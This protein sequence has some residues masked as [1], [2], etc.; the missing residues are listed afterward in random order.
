MTEQEKAI[1]LH[2]AK[3]FFRTRIVT[4]HIKNTIKCGNLAEFNVN[5]FLLKYLAYYFTGNN[6]AES[7]A[8]C[9]IYPRVLGTSITTS[10]GSQLQFFCS[11]V[12]QGYASVIPG[13]DL[14]FIDQ[15]DGRR[16]YCQVKAGPNTINAS[17]VETVKNHFTGIRNL[18]RV[19]RLSLDLSDLIVGVFYGEE[20]ELSTNYIAINESFPVYIGQEFWERLTGE[21]S[22][23][24]ELIDAFGEV[25]I[26]VDGVHMLEQTVSRLASQI[27]QMNF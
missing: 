9:L 23:Y 16:K 13:L 25:A 22:F 19:N 14:E 8:K 10:F 12:L 15:I 5:P 26:E 18:A 20:A 11:D 27:D 2:R 4:S 7:M 21:R 24:F 6:N 17:D 3:T 1:I